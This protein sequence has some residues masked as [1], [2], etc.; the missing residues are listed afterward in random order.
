[1]NRMWNF[2]LLGVISII[3]GIINGVLYDLTTAEMMIYSLLCWLLLN[4]FKKII[5]VQE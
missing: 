3:I 1:M 2:I 5:E 4:E